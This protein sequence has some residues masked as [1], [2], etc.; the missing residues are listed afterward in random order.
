MKDFLRLLAGRLL[1]QLLRLRSRPFPF[2]PGTLLVVSPHADDETLGC[3]GLLSLKC[4]R[5][6][7]VAVVYLTDSAGSPEAGGHAAHAERRRLEAL[8]ALATLG[9]STTQA[10]FLNAPD[11]RLNRLE[12]AER[13]RLVNALSEQ[14]GALRPAEILVPYWGGGSS[15]HDAAVLVARD[16]LKNSGVPAIVWEYPIWAWWDPRR[17]TGQLRRPQE[18]FRLE[19]GSVRATK[20]AA[21]ACHVSQMAPAAPGDAPPLPPVLAKLATGPVEFYFLRN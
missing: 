10:H 16:A 18:N 4:A 8:A 1:A 14:I 13:A 21:L 9:V 11:G 12:P 20:H 5:G 17:L 19:L 3:G 2:R 15:E 6:E 7:P